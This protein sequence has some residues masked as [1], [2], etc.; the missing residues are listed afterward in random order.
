MRENN[1]RNI[2]AKGGA[3]IALITDLKL[4]VA[5]VG[6]GEKLEDWSEFDARA[7][8]QGLVTAS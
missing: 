2:W 1:V 7:Y 6:V 4:P 5:L 3:V 8:A